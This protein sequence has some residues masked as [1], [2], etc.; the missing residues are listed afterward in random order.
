MHMGHAIVNLLL[1]RS[2]RPSETIAEIL[3]VSS[4][5]IVAT[6]AGD[7]QHPLHGGPTRTEHPRGA[8][9]GEGRLSLPM[10]HGQSCHG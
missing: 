6:D 9:S 3:A 10:S 8:V 1:W 7:S 5:C 4:T 2:E